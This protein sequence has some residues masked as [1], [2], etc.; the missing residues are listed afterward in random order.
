VLDKTHTSK[1][2]KTAL[3]TTKAWGK[4]FI[5]FEEHLMARKGNKRFIF[6]T[7]IYQA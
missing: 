4:W 7:Y 3:H 5:N 1:Q 6:I 2:H